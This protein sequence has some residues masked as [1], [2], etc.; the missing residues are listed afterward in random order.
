MVIMKRQELHTPR[1][2]ANPYQEASILRKGFGKII[3]KEPM[4]GE[5]YD[6]RAAATAI[7]TLALAGSVITGLAA[8]EIASNFGETTSNTTETPTVTRITTDPISLRTEVQEA[9]EA[10][11]YDPEETTINLPDYAAEHQGQD[12]RNID[13]LSSTYEITVIDGV[14]NVTRVN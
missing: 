5:E 9:L 10:N 11:G 13:Y 3:G 4:P 6:K 1:H 14:A 2:A 7:A 8:H 12:P